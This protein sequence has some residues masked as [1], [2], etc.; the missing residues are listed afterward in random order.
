MQVHANARLGPAGRIALAEMVASGSTLRAA[1]AAFNVAPA[2]AHRWWHRFRLASAQERSAGSWARDHS[3][4]P[5]HQPRRL[6]ADAEARICAVRQATGWGP[7]LVA[8]A[9][10]HPHSTVWK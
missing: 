8:G 5:H 7:R 4:R 9:T 6:A 1:A 2:T 10:G 3:S